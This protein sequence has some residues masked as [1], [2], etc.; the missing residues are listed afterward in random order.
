M[1]GPEVKI[2]H[3]YQSPFS[4]PIINAQHNVCV[5]INRGPAVGK[6]VSSGVDSVPIKMPV[7]HII[8]AN[9]RVSP[10]DNECHELRYNAECSVLVLI[11]I[12]YL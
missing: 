9:Q 12:Y 4:F 5:K 2:Y 10:S 8:T 6:S 1:C 11:N 3:I 7:Y